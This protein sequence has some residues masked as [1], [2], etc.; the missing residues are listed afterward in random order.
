M[1]LLKTKKEKRTAAVL[2]AISVVALVVWLLIKRLTRQQLEHSP[3]DVDGV[4]M[5]EYETVNIWQPD[6][7]SDFDHNTTVTNGDMARQLQSDLNSILLWIRQHDIAPQ[8]KDVPNLLERHSKLK[9]WTPLE[10]DGVIGSKTRAL[11]KYITGSDTTTLKEVLRRAKNWVYYTSDITAPVSI[12]SN[13]NTWW[14]NM[15]SDLMTL[16]SPGLKP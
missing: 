3:S 8:H 15:L 2:V 1:K 12:S 13:S 11:T 4:D 14:G 10:I 6:T 16:G 7:I 9:E 5:T